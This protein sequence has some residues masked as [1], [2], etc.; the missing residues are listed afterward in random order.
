[1]SAIV[2]FAFSIVMVYGI[3]GK[4]HKIPHNSLRMDLM[5][6]NGH[7]FPITFQNTSVQPNA[8]RASV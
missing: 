7:K 4:P 2:L 8:E 5:A 6:I 3:E 1:M